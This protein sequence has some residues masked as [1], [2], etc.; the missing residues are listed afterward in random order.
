MVAQL[1][2]RVPIGLSSTFWMTKLNEAYRWISQKGNFVWDLKEPTELF[3][4]LV[5]NTI[6]KLPPD[7]DPGKPIYLSGPISSAGSSNTSVSTVIPFKPWDELLDQQ[8]AEVV[9]P[10]GLFSC[11]SIVS[12][13]ENNPYP[14][15]S[16]LYDY[17]VQFYP[18]SAAP[19]PSTGDFTFKM[20]YHADVGSTEFALGTSIYFP[21]PNSFDNLLIELAEAEA[22]RI[23]GLA[24]WEIIQKRAES[25]IMNLLDSYRSTKNVLAG[26]VD[27]QKQVSEKKL[28][29]QERA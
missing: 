16:K 9:A 7:C 3:T 10:T 27:Q 8:Y 23:Y 17:A 20:V 1:Q 21:T 26:L 24:G 11:F 18:V 5:N 25:A 13:F 29:A 6:K 22:R 4:L 15:P 28:M 2:T 14:P 12:R 19:T